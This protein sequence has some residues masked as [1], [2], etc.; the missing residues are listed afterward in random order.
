MEFLILAVG[1]ELLSGDTI[2][3]NSQWIAKKLTQNGHKVRRMVTVGDV[4]ED[5]VREIRNSRE[6]FIIVTGGLGTTPD[7]LTREAIAE[8]LKKPLIE[9]REVKRMLS[10]YRIDDEIR[11]RMSLL[12]EG[13]EPVPNN[14][15]VAPG[16]IVENILV[17]PGV[18]K[19]MM[20]IFNKVIGRF[21][22]ESYWEEWIETHKKEVD[23][24]PLL[25]KA[26]NKFPSIRIGSYPQKTEK[27]GKVEFK[28]RI[29]ISGK[30]IEMVKEVREF[31][32]RGLSS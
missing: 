18:P 25:E 28:V 17:M 32:E 6:D 9:F 14:E 13:S 30:D 31:I 29:K 24:T 22:S 7:D 23:I 19:E 2:D 16:F 21:G 27:N 11:E 4:K 26:V 3:T 8:A 1:N 15:G 10:Q 20:D 5:I 12:P